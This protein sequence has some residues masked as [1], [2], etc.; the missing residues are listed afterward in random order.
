MRLRRPD[1]YLVY[2]RGTCKSNVCVPVSYDVSPLLLIIINFGNILIFRYIL[3]LVLFSLCGA[4]LGV[5]IRSD[6]LHFLFGECSF[7][8]RQ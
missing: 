2:N 8:Q 3:V 6:G 5:V 1:V 7:Q 4:R